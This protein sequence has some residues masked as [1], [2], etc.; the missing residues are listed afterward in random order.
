VGLVIIDMQY[1]FGPTVSSVLPGVLALVRDARKA[2]EPIFVLSFSGCGGTLEEVLSAV[3]GYPGTVYV[4]KGFKN[5]T[6]PLTRAIHRTGLQLSRL[7][8][9]GVW[10][11]QCVRETFLGMCEAWPMIEMALISDA[12]G[13]PYHHHRGL[14]D[15]RYNARRLMNARVNRR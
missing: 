12:C 1:Q 3:R 7:R 5:G 11:S 10:T 4:R 8:F 13:D 15:I 6:K 14:Q 2:G 9:C